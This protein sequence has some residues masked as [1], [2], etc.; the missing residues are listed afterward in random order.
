MS[1]TTPVPTLPTIPQVVAPVAP[2]VPQPVAQLGQQ[3]EANLQLFSSPDSVEGPSSFL[4][5][6]GIVA[7]IAFLLIVVI[8]F[9]ILMR[10]GTS[11]LGWVFMPSSS[12]TLL[13][14]IKDATK[15]LVIPQDPKASGAIPV[16][17]SNNREDGIEFTWS[18]WININ[19]LTYHKAGEYKHIFHKGN[20]PSST[21]PARDGMVQPNNAPGLYIHPTKNALVVV[22]N[23][24]NNINEEIVIDDIPLNKWVN[25]VIR[26]EDRN[27]DVYI[28]GV[29]AKRRRLGGVP[30]QNYGDVYV[31]LNGGFAGSVADLKYWNYAVSPGELSAVTSSGPDTSMKDS[32]SGMPPYFS[33][34]WYLNQ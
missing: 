15:L 20:A 10:L 1:E 19:E 32:K 24:F 11:F 34:R 16:I 13:S 25:V 5:S 21:I 2:L 33:M 3:A 29:I 12:P 17:R 27:L 6:N 18:I 8:G 9:V 23:T 7:R 30:K 14:G 4:E 22:M 31:N 26:V 28:N